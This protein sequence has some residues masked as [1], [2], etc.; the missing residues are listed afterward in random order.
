MAQKIIDGNLYDTFLVR[1][2]G[3]DG[4][5]PVILSDQVEIK[6]DEGSPIPVEPLGIPTIARQLTVTATSSS[7][8]LTTGCTRISMYAR[9][10]AVRYVV[11]IGSQTATAT[12]HFLDAGSSVDIRVPSGATLAAIRDGDQNA[13]LEISELS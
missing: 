12:S 6:N 3:N 9:S 8:T 10:G 13:T 1:G 11:G 5:V 2:E 7:V 4:K